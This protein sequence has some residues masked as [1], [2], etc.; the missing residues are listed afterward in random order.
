MK[1]ALLL[2]WICVARGGAEEAFDFK[3]VEPIQIEKADYHLN[4]DRTGGSV[5]ATLRDGNGNLCFVHYLTKDA[6]PE[7]GGGSLSY[8]VPKEDHPVRFASGS[9]DERRL[10]NLIRS[11]PICRT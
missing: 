4:G 6:G 7:S 9:E 2:L 8:R 10:L 3:L 11:A 1:I 5:S